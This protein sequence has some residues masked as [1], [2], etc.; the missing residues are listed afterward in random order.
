MRYDLY[1][2]LNF[3]TSVS[4][5]YSLA[6]IIIYRYFVILVSLAASVTY[7]GLFTTTC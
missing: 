1:V 6:T 7:P 3:K 5:I 4:I 2:I